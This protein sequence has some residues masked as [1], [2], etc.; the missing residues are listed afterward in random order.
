VSG[1]SNAGGYTPAILGSNTSNEGTG[2]EG[3]GYN[4]VTGIA[5]NAAN[6][7]ALVGTQTNSQGY[8]IYAS[9]GNNVFNVSATNPGYSYFG[10]KVGIG[11][12]PTTYGLEVSGG[13]CLVDQSTAPTLSKKTWGGLF[14]ANNSAAIFVEDSG[15]TSTQ[16]SSHKDPIDIDPQAQTS[17]ADPTVILPF[18]FHHF[19]TLLGVGQ[20]VDMSKMVAW[21]EK[22]MQTELGNQAGQLTYTYNL[23]TSQCLTVAQWQQDM[24]EAQTAKALG[25]LQVMPWIKMTL[26]PNGEVPAEAYESVPEMNIVMQKMTIAQKILDVHSMTV[27]TVNVQKVMPQEVATGKTT[28]RLKENYMFKD[29]DIYRK[30]TVND[31]NLNALN[32]NYPQLPQWILTRI[33]NGQSANV[34]VSEMIKQVRATIQKA[35][36]KPL[37]K[38]KM[39]AALGG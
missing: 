30:P 39:S 12:S 17:F 8:C 2:V 19:N 15:Y 13:I 35:E 28:N 23:P 29:G 38:D 18:S 7:A 33:K 26:G 25:Q 6:S 16:L 36:L 5:N 4:A 27:K 32:A 22:K 1:T 37:G 34:S 11:I 3:I 20:D 31:I 24:I 10:Q 14:Y 21:I 9:N